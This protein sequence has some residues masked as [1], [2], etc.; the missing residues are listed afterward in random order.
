M[1]T[2]HRL[3]AA[4]RECAAQAGPANAAKYEAF[5]KRAETGEFDDYADTHV[6][7]ITQLNNELMAEGFTKFAARVR[8]GEFDA[9]KEESDA[10]AASPSGHAALKMLSGDRPAMQELGDGPVENEYRAKMTAIVQSLDEIFNGPAR[11][12]ARQTGF[13][14]LVFPYGEKEGRCN[15]MSNG[16]N[17]DDVKVMLREQLARFEGQP[18]TEGKA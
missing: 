11:G 3:A 2:K 5:A 10:W 18:M 16:A 17:R 9:T 6:Y 1:E 13:I 7:P 4:L 15:Y 14:L 12:Q 8:D